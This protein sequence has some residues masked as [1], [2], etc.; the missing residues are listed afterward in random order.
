MHISLETLDR[1]T[2]F[3]DSLADLDQPDRASEV[4]LPALADLIGCDIATYQEMSPEPHRLGTYTE[5]PA[6]S[7]DPAA[8]AVFEAHIDEHPLVTHKRATADGGPASISDVMSRQRFRRLGIYSE[9]FR[10]VPTDDQIAFTMPGVT[11]GQVVG[12]ALSRSEQDFSRADSAVLRSVVAPMR[13]ALRR[14]GRRHRAQG[15][16]AA[17][18]EGLADLTDRELQVLQMAARGR[19]NL[20]IARAI[21]LSPRTIAKH[22]EHIYRKLGVTSRAAAVYRTAGASGPRQVA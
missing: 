2:Q 22:L 17:E 13:N 12:I 18:P 8:V 6:G 19:T 11:D 14:S 1:A 5:Y 7:L 15:A 21:D 16:V 20:A 3:V 10:H 4:M 9:Y